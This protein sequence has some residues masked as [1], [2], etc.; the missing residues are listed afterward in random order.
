MGYKSLSSN[1]ITDPSKEHISS[2]QKLTAIDDAD[3]SVYE[4][5]LDF[6]FN[7]ENSDLYNIAITGVYGSGKSSIIN[8]Y[9]KKKDKK[10]IHISLTR[11]DVCAD[12]EANN[13]INN[14]AENDV[15]ADIIEKKIVNQLVQQIPENYIPDSKFQIKRDFKW[16][17]VFLL[18]VEIV[19]TFGLLSYVKNFDSLLSMINGFE[20]P[21]F[22]FF[23]DPVCFIAAIILMFILSVIICIQIVCILKNNNLFSKISIK[24][25]QI[26]FENYKEDKSYFNR[27]TDEILYILQN[28][29]NPRNNKEKYDGIIFED[30][31]RFSTVDTV[32]F[33]KL[34]ELCILSNDRIKG[35]HI[36]NPNTLRFFYLLND[37]TFKSKD[38]TKF[39]DFI[40]PVIPVV[41]S[42]NAYAKIKKIFSDTSYI[43]FLNDR[44]LR[45]LS[46]YFDDYR[47]IKNISNEFLIYAHKVSI[48]DHD[49]NEL[50]S[51]IV[52]KNCFPKDFSELQIRAGYVFS[53]F[54]QKDNLITK[55]KKQFENDKSKL[56]HVNTYSLS[57]LISLCDS[58]AFFDSIEIIGVN[59]D[60]NIKD[61][62]NFG[63]L[64]YLIVS[65]YLNDL[66]YRDYIACFDE[67]G[68][69]LCDKNF[70]IGINS[71][72]GNQ[73]DYKL[74]DLDLVFEY[75]NSNDFDVQAVR[76]YDLTDYIICNQKKEC[77]EV[78]VNQLKEYRDFDY[79]AQY[80]NYSDRYQ[81][82]IYELCERWEDFLSQ[83]ISNDN[84]FMTPDEKQNVVIT[85]ISVCRRDT[86]LKQNDSGVL[87]NY[88]SKS[89]NNAS[90]L[91][92]YLST[93]IDTFIDLDVMI[94]DLDTQIG[95]DSLRTKIIENK[96]YQLT[97][98]NL[99]SILKK[100]LHC[101]QDNID[102]R[103][104]SSLI[105]S[106]SN[107]VSEYI[108]E[109]LE[110][111][112][113]LLVNELE[114]QEDSPETVAM[115]T[116]TNIDPEI[117]NAYICISKTKIENILIINPKYWETFFIKHLVLEQG[118]NVLE[119]YKLYK[120]NRVL[121][122]FFNES[123]DLG[124]M[125]FS[126]DPQNAILLWN[127]VYKN[128]DI[129][130]VAYHAL[131][132]NIGRVISNFVT[133]NL[134]EKKI[135][136]L[137]EHHLISITTSTLLF[138]RKNYSKLMNEF[139]CSDI[140]SYIEI[141]HGALYCLNEV[142]NLLNV[143]S[144][145]DEKKL[146]LLKRTNERISVIG[147]ELSDSLFAEIISNHFYESD[148]LYISEKFDLLDE[149]CKEAAYTYAIRKHIDSVEFANNSSKQLLKKVFADNE[150]SLD[151]KS[152][153][154]GK[155]LKQKFDT[156]EIYSLLRLANEEKVA[157]VF[158]NER[159]R[160]LPVIDDVGHRKILDVLIEYG[161]IDSYY[162]DETGYLK[163]KRKTLREK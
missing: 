126:S 83:L 75:L 24:G 1:F 116:S 127:D 100:E 33:E 45:G 90:C 70:L 78:F 114:E 82:F 28:V 46:L 34:R 11:F 25:T 147:I 30:L 53:L 85:A 17:R 84:S 67:N 72:K 55:V 22:R 86:I 10:F 115:I 80:L 108:K 142:V 19:L 131:V 106:E 56:I 9:A 104:I 87:T 129:N 109:N 105:N 139:I 26:E 102:N 62:K 49:Y 63:L 47:L 77:L 138:F 16:A 71:R 51:V 61:D 41:D 88:L 38:R 58:D 123:K 112:L 44:F 64:K 136:I 7:K 158:S 140:V 52:Y 154:L 98:S 8:T 156:F 94:Q 150:L 59:G 6:V 95:E 103:F 57:K 20:L 2:F 39:F 65:G 151:K 13:K 48:T 12:K 37:C 23:V 81:E 66:T 107:A 134:E 50:L 43:D 119:F 124:K 74:V 144:V 76:N 14:N 21:L 132:K 31:D 113:S 153:V 42:S 155:L 125:D 5:A 89:I 146:M 141:A 93:V 163:I 162:K 120:C 161:Y 118:H 92:P 18:I 97:F 121:I 149:K 152:V 15:N 101:T 79:I 159:K 130:D 68:M 110:S 137:L 96:L 40:I 157:R 4:D 143:K 133:A 135:L 29:S 111:V 3:I 160:L 148:L 145:D 35:T 60:K 73:F 117:I 36:K 122:S 128:N 54:E 91:T 32:I 27:H 99:V 69:S